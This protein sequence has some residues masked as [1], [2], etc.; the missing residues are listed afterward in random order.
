MPLDSIGSQR[1]LL[2]SRHL[3]FENFNMDVLAENL[4]GTNSCVYINAF[5]G[6]NH[7]ISI[8]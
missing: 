8:G 3:L 4:Y 5:R 1:K 6:R 7:E 2:T